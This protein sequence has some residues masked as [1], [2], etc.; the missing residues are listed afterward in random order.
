MIWVEYHESIDRF[1]IESE[2]SVTLKSL[3]Y[4]HNQVLESCRTLVEDHNMELGEGGD[5]IP[6][7]LQLLNVLH[8]D[9]AENAK[10]SDIEAECTKVLT[11]L[12]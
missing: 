2:C 6:Y 10:F 11:D 3:S 5:S 4:Y 7:N 9:F 8:A 12:I 1:S